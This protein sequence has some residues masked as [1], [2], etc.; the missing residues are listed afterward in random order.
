MIAPFIILPFI[1]P[2]VEFP[3]T[4]FFIVGWSS[5][6][7]LS[8][9]FMT[10]PTNEKTLI[11]FYERIHPGGV[12]WKP[13]SDKLPH[14]KSDNGYTQLFIDWVAGCV[15]VIFTLFGF[16]KI[17]LGEQGTGFQFLFIAGCAGYVIYWHLS[18]MGW[19]KVVQ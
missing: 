19:E 16:G 18:N 9:T 12:L 7:W 14:V 13:I 17:I 4:L 5:I 10:A 8:V 2:F 3:H 15:L 6:V 1:K 11:S